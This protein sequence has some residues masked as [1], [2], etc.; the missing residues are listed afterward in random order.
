MESSFLIPVNDYSY[1]KEIKLKYEEKKYILV[2]KSDSTK[3]AFLYI[4]KMKV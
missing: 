1:N 2:I 3:K 4:K